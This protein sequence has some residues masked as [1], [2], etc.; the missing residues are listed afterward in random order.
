MHQMQQMSSVHP[1]G[2]VFES[3]RL[4]R[5]EDQSPNSIA[6]LHEQ[7][8]HHANVAHHQVTLGALFAPKVHRSAQVQ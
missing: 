2:N 5:I 4:G 8:R 1:G 7:L 3:I 6:P